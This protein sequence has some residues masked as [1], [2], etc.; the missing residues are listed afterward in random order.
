MSKILQTCSPSKS[1]ENI[2]IDRRKKR[3]KKLEEKVSGILGFKFSLILCLVNLGKHWS[4]FSNW[5][6][7][8]GNSG[9]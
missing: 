9:E 7:I 1:Q 3:R 2:E 5:G 4:L 8:W 6:D